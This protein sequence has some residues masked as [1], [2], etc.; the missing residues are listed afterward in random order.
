MGNVTGAILAPVSCTPGQVR[1]L[2][3]SF[4]N[5]LVE[6]RT[7][8]CEAS[9]DD[10]IEA[11]TEAKEER[12]LIGVP[13]GDAPPLDRLLALIAWPEEDALVWTGEGAARLALLRPAGLL[14]EA[15]SRA[16]DCQGD[17]EAWLEASG[18]LRVDDAVLGLETEREEA[19]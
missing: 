16:R 2:E 5:A 17:L 13:E 19:S 1:A 12:V 6:T 4:A 10:W 8:D 3:A 18:V 15:R 14:D 11:L 9:V 7:L